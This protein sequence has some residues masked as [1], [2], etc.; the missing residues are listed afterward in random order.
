MFRQPPLTAALSGPTYISQRP[1]LEISHERSSLNASHTDK[2]T[3]ISLLENRKTK[4]SSPN[5]QHQVYKYKLFWSNSDFGTF[6]ECITFKE[7]LVAYFTTKVLWNLEVHLQYI[8][9]KCVH[10]PLICLF[11][12]QF[13]IPA[14]EPAPPFSKSPISFSSAMKD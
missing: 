8:I 5:C 9:R 6:I 12:S 1:I 3:N 11:L 7:V 14:L 10:F 4:D 2:A 13:V